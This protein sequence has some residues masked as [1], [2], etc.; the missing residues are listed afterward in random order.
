[1]GATSMLR[2]HGYFAFT[3]LEFTCNP[4]TARI[5]F[6]YKNT[7]NSLHFLRTSGNIMVA[8]PFNNAYYGINTDCYDLCNVRNGVSNTLLH[9]TWES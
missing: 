9:L 4:L 5:F 7:H 2:I 1:M 8:P 3:D 6:T